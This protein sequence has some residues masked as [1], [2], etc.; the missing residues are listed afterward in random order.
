MRSSRSR[1]HPPQDLVWPRTSPKMTLWVLRRKIV[2]RE[3][4]YCAG[5]TCCRLMHLQL[6]SVCDCT[7]IV[8]RKTRNKIGFPGIIMLRNI[9]IPGKPILFLVFRPTMGVQSQTERSCRCIRRQHVLPA[10]YLRSRRTIFRRST[11]SVIFGEV[12][13]Q[14]RS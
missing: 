10:Q 14:T 6:L 11:H 7:P 4:R 2:R 3:R 9:M 1:I 13:G 12:L 5:R 8:G